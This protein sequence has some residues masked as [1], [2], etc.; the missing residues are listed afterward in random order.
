MVPAKDEAPISTFLRKACVVTFPFA[1]SLGIAHAASSNIFPAITLVPQTFSTLFSI[2]I[3]YF[4]SKRLNH[5]NGSPGTTGVVYLAKEDPKRRLEK[6]WVFLGDLVALAGLLTCLVFTWLT[7]GSRSYWW[8]SM[9]EVILGTYA[10][11]PFMINMY[12]Y[13]PISPYLS[14][15]I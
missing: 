15:M 7:L 3:V 13:T 9:G 12:V 10:T 14:P 5:S 11:V 4:S 8:N 1:F 2:A 6:F